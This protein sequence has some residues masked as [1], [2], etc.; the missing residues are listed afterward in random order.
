VITL[1]RQFQVIFTVVSSL[2]GYQDLL[3]ESL[4]DFHTQVAAMALS[5]K[6]SSERLDSEHIFVQRPFSL[7]LCYLK[8]V[9]L[10]LRPALHNLKVVNLLR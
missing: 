6:L 9:D 1:G 7:L 3:F 10:L 2:I 8:V 5:F 4:D